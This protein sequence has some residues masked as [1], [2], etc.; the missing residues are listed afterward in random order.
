MKRMKKLHV[1]VVQDYEDQQDSEDQRG[2]DVSAR[3]SF[4][5]DRNTI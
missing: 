1:M 4:L 5:E 3:I 2:V